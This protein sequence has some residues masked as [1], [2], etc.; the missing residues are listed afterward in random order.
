MTAGNASLCPKPAVRAALVAASKDA[1][2]R[3]RQAPLGGMEKA[4]AGI[5]AFAAFAIPRRSGGRFWRPYFQ[6]G[7]VSYWGK[8]SVI[9]NH[10]AL[11]PTKMCLVGRMDG[12]STRVPMV[13]WT[14]LP[15]RTT[16]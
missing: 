14:N 15:S 1:E 11:E 12:S 4:A 5:I 7:S 8:S 10:G 9:V 3:G 2:R 6:P 16:E 13:T